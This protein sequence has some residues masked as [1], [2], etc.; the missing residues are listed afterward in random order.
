[1]DTFRW[2]TRSL[3][4]KRSAALNSSENGGKKAETRIISK[5]QWIYSMKCIKSNRFQWESVASAETCPRNIHFS[6]GFTKCIFV[7][8]CKCRR[9]RSSKLYH[10]ISYWWSCSHRLLHCH[11]LAVA[12]SASFLLS[13][14]KQKSVKLKIVDSHIYIEAPNMPKIVT[15]I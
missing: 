5:V 3:I 15:G 8:L 1:M 2:W 14:G 4:H 10:R 6:F 9:L 13:E 12:I 11:L 7:Y